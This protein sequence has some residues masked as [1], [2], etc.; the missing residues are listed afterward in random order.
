DAEI[1]KSVVPLTA[2]AIVTSA[3]PASIDVTAEVWV[4]TSANLTDD[5]IKDAVA[6]KLTDYFE[7][8]P[9]GG[10]VIPPSAVGYVYVHTLVAQIEAVSPYMFKVLVS[11]PALDVSL[12]GTEVATLGTVTTT[13]HQITP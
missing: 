13:V 12:A 9:I 8:I 2:Q 11:D 5:Q 4:Y 6:A 10:H 1:Q 3:D 7:T